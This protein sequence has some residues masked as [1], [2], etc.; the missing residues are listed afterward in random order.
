MSQAYIFFEIMDGICYDFGYILLNSDKRI[1]EQRGK[2]IISNGALRLI[3]LKKLCIEKNIL[4][5][6]GINENEVMNIIEWLYNICDNI[7]CNDLKTLYSFLPSAIKNRNNIY[8]INETVGKN[9]KSPGQS[10]SSSYLTG[11]AIVDCMK[12]YEL[13]KIKY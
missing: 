5:S 2:L 11:I 3:G 4:L 6:I 8:D 9:N 13:N 1:I 12:M 10:S 7:I